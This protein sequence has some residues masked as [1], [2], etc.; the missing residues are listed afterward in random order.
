IIAGELTGAGTSNARSVTMDNT[1]TS[2]NIGSNVS[3]VNTV[4]GV[5]VGHLGTLA[6]GTAAATAYYLK[7]QGQVQVW[8]GGTLNIGTAGSPMPSDSS[9]VLEFNNDANVKFGLEV[10][11]GGTVNMRG[12]AIANVKAK[13][14]ANAAAAAV[15]LT[16]D[17]ATGWKSG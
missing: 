8:G 7:M 9:A 14:A 13:L 3:T 11:D 1:S 6:Y 4:N 16:T 12:A 17:I 5:E 2:L 15:S 10:L